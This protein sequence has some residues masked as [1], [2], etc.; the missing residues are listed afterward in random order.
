M[1]REPTGLRGIIK[2]KIS[3]ESDVAI[4]YISANNLKLFRQYPSPPL[5]SEVLRECLLPTANRTK[6][7]IGFSNGFEDE[8]G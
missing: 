6:P 7:E 1:V 2:K 3:L 4:V 5:S 8:S